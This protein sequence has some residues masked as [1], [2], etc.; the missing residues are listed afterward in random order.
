MV[1]P[2]EIGKIFKEARE[3]RELSIEQ[4]YGQCRIHPNVIRDIETGVFDRIGKTYLKSFLKKYSAFL[5]L[6]TEDIIRKYE[7]ISSE[8]PS[9]EFDLGTEEKEETIKVFRAGAEAATGRK[10]GGFT[11]ALSALTGKKVEAALVV[12]LSVVFV[13]LVFVLIG[14]VS[15]R[16]SPSRQQKG[17]AVSK[18][19]PVRV[20]GTV[21]GK[22]S[23]TA[24]V[25]KT[26]LEKP[27]PGAETSAPVVLTLKA[28][29]EVW[30]Q[31]SKGKSVLFSG[32]LKEGDSK[33]W[34]S[35]GTLTVWTG[36]AQMLNF[37]VN[38]RKIGVVTQ[39]VVKNIKVSSKGISIDDVWISRL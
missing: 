18:E 37:I 13:V 28:H 17:E 35:D 8:M 38:T 6:D 21:P 32:I 19:A 27:T 23:K 16:M 5:G 30:I 12:V 20:S 3:S 22:A 2:K 26:V 24:A 7:S 36:K 14:V 1:T 4:A 29:G 25:S 34:R 15:S 10:I 33:T 31:V 9:L 39:G 11:D